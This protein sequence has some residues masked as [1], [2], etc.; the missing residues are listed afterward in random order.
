M[1]RALLTSLRERFGGL[2]ERFGLI[3]QGDAS[4]TRSTYDL[5]LIAPFLDRQFKLK[6][7]NDAHM[8]EEKTKKIT[9]LVKRLVLEAAL[10]M[11]GSLNDS[12][13]AAAFSSPVNLDTSDSDTT[14]STPIFKRKRLFSTFS[15]EILPLTKKTRSC[16]TEKI[17]DEIALFMKEPTDDPS[18]LF[19][20]KEFYPC[21]HRLAVRVFCV[22][23]TSA[24]VERV[25]S[26]SGIIMRS[27][28]SRLTKNML[29]KLTLLNC[30][31]H[32]L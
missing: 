32:L 20:K 9:D 19:K 24:P 7:L 14:I 16:V 1:C 21:L 10:Q 2:L 29:S 17:Q 18:L 27:H 31:Q 8:S 28:R 12:S 11:N 5:Y 3:N 13:N 25:F 22:P 6:R 4:K 15:D 26:L 30:N 23:A